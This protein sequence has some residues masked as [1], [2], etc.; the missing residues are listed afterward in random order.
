M[1]RLAPSNHSSRSRLA[2]LAGLALTSVLALAQ[3]KGKGDQALLSPT[4]GPH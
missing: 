4:W 1:P 3:G 2:V